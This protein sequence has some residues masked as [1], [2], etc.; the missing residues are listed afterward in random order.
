MRT[1]FTKHRRLSWTCQKSSGQSLALE[2]WLSATVSR[3][4]HSFPQIEL[5]AD[6]LKSYSHVQSQKRWPLNKLGGRT[7]EVL[8]RSKRLSIYV[9]ERTMFACFCRV[10]Y[11]CLP[12]ASL[13]GFTVRGVVED[14][15]RR[16]SMPVY[17]AVSAG[18]FL[19]FDRCRM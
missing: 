7:T 14:C 17:I 11:G 18:G 16:V 12:C 6:V 3:A 19:A 10:C 5:A 1:Q 4:R 9:S 13:L 8:C 15:F 2:P